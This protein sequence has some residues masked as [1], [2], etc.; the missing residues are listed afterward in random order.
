MEQIKQLFPN[1]QNRTPEVVRLLL[2]APDGTTLRFA[3]GVYDFYAEGALGGY[4]CPGCNRNGD[5]QVIFPLLHRRNVT[6]DGGGAK[7]LF[8]DR[9]FPFIA[10]DCERVTLKNFSVDFSFPRCLEATVTEMTQEG[11]FLEIDP[12]AYRYGVNEAGNLLIGAGSET[13]SSSERRYFLEQR[14]WHCFL[15]VGDIFYE[16]VNSPAD[17][18][19]CQAEQ[20]TRGIFLRYLPGS[21]RVQFT[22]G[23]RLMLSYDELRENDVIFLERCRNTI[24]EYVHI[25]HGAGMGVVGQCCENLNLDHFSVDPQDDGL[26]A[27]TAD[28]I[29]LTNFS[30][31]V[32]LEN[33]RVD[34]SVDDALSIHGFYTCVE[35]ITDRKKAVVRLMHLS[36]AGTNPY[37]PGDRLIVSDGKSMARNGVVTVKR[38]YRRD[39]L[40]LIFLE[41]EE[42]LS[43]LLK[44]GD[45]LENSERTPEV[46]IR[47]CTFL[48]FPAIR[49]ASAKRTVF[50]HNVVKNCHGLLVNDLMQYWH[51]SGCVDGLIIQD[52]LFE[53]METG[54]HAF[55]QRPD[56]SQ[57]RHR[58]IVIRR[59][60]FVNCQTGIKACSVDGLMVEGNVFEENEQTIVV[61][62]CL[63]TELRE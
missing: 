1:G 25:L 13:F 43:G 18:I 24:I 22:C 51:A 37:F 61:E 36:Q 45:F 9:V 52:N 14:D 54:V 47:H 23:K 48:N 20:R 28:A 17:V 33:V 6:I 2:N 39:D 50:E 27:T 60:R 35:Q 40:A 57:V 15:S 31:K 46:E 26:Y 8:H 5:K 19:Y 44:P 11:F 3:P 41:F 49:L 55:V 10:Q 34:R 7:F 30:G 29:L 38:A 56:S 63:N 12:A 59:N 53:N 4:F 58:G 21:V 32:C 62:N 16:N 42:E